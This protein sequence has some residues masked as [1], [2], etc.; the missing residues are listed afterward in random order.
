MTKHYKEET[1]DGLIFNEVQLLLAEKRTLLSTLR[2]GITVSILPFTVVSF[3]IATSRYYDLI[4]VMH[5]M[6]PLMGSCTILA[7]LGA[8]LI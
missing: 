7:V 2:T 8:Y 3:L 5:L 6:I 4:Q 1:P